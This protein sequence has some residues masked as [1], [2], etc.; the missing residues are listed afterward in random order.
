MNTKTYS[1]KP[2]DVERRWIVID[3]SDAPLGRISTVI[4]T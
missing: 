3:A 1:A 2:T 4:A